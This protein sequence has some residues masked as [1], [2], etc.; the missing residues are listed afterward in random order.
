MYRIQLGRPI[1]YVLQM[2]ESSRG[3]YPIQAT[4]KVGAARRALPIGPH[5]S[6]VVAFA[7]QPDRIKA[8]PQ[9]DGI[10]EPRFAMLKLAVACGGALPNSLGDLVRPWRI[11]LSCKQLLLV[12]KWWHLQCSFSAALPFINEL[13]KN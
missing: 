5:L 12:H 7:H 2:Y 3:W 8:T 10:G 9:P 1:A 4:R 13:G 11:F 6:V